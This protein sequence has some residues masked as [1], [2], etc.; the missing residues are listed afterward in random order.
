MHGRAHRALARWVAALTPDNAQGEFYLTDIVAAAAR[1]GIPVVAH[2]AA[3]ERDVR[4][5]N[6]RAQLAGRRARCCR[7]AARRR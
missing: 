4:G 3:D 6:D 5:I 1:D 7:R 2:V